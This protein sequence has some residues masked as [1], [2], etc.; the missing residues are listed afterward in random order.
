MGRFFESVGEV[1]GVVWSGW[2]VF[3][4][5]GVCVRGVSVVD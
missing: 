2:S 5:W 3:G 4:V 1:V